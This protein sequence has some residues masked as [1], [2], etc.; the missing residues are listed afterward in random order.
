[1]RFAPV[2]CVPFLCVLSCSSA[3]KPPVDTGSDAVGN[4]DGDGGS[5]SPSTDGP[6]P[7]DGPGMSTDAGMSSD[8]GGDGDAQPG[9]GGPGHEDA[10]TSTPD[11]TDT[12]RCKA[13][14]LVWKSGAKTMYESYPEPG[15]VECIEFS[16]CKYEGLFSACSGKKSE[17]WVAAHNIVAVFPDFDDLELH[18]LCLRMGDKVIVATVYD[19]CADDDC[20]NCCTDHK[21][22]ANQLIDVEEYTEQRW[23][24]LRDGDVEWAD[25]GPTQGA[26]CE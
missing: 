26:G 22:A 23:G 1:M 5:G 2:F 17:A 18:D 20:D 12:A 11:F 3:P 13:P 10:S 16:G 15:S 21:G 7:P 8:P 9:E 6:K 19:Q 24:V 25:L 4:G 14:G